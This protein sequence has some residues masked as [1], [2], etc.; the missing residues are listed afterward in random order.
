M[1]KKFDYKTFKF[2]DVVKE[3]G[4]R[5]ACDMHHRNEDVNANDIAKRKFNKIKESFTDKTEQFNFCSQ[6]EKVY[7]D[8]RNV[9]V[10]AVHSYSAKK[11]GDRYVFPSVS[12][13]GLWD[14][15]AHIVGL[16]KEV[17]YKVVNDPVLIVNY[18]DDCVENFGYAFH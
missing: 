15:T 12:D 3:I 7:D 1:T 5:E 14:L 16:G 11:Y 10:D 17:Y 8:Y 6:V 4:W 9:L 18:K 13:D 2:W